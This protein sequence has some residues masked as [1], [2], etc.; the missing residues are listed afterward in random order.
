MDSVSRFTTKAERYARYRWGYAPEAIQAIFDITVLT[1]QAI[2]A[3]IGA[4]TGLLTKEFV[5]RVERIYAVEPNPNMRHFAD[6]FLGQHPSF[7]SVDGKAEAT[8]LGDHSVDLIVV[9]QA[10]HWFTPL[11]ARVEFERIL[12]PDGWIAAVFHSKIEQQAIY[13]SVE[14]ICTVENG[15][16]T[17]PSPKPPVGESHTDVYFGVG[18]GIKLHFPQTWLENWE[19]FSG[20]I[21]SDSHSPDDTS[22]AFPRF[23]AALREIFDQYSNDGY[24]QVSGGTDLVLGQLRKDMP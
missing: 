24:I 3:D 8:S 21:L 4:G 10:L 18:C 14:A 23:L 20:A 12:T 1:S 7:I 15:W 6:Q 13:D 2:V 22:P 9:G 19:I 17:T 5:N 11:A 16:D